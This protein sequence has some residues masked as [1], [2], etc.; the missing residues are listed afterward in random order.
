M[1]G[2]SHTRYVNFV[3]TYIACDTGCFVFLRFWE[4]IRMDP[5]RA[6]CHVAFRVE[7]RN[8]FIRDQGNVT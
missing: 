7:V 1:G 3:C 8:G 4:E 6:G 5:G 2:H